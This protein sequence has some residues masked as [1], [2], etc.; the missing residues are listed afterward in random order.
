MNL[1]DRELAT[2]LAALRYWREEMALYDPASA[3]P[4]YFAL[5]ESPWSSRLAPRRSTTSVRESTRPQERLRLEWLFRGGGY[6]VCIGPLS[7]AE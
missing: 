5:A 7:P 6:R 1:T 2:V 4:E 3:F